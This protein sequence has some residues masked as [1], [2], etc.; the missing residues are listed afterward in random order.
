QASDGNLYGTTLRGGQFG[1]GT[2]YGLKPSGVGYTVLHSF[3]GVIAGVPPDGATPY[4]RLFEF[5]PGVLAGT[6]VAGGDPNLGTVYTIAFGGAPYAIIHT[7]VGGGDGANPTAELILHTDQSTGLTLMYGTT[8]NGGSA[9]LGTVYHLDGGGGNYCIAYDFLGGP[10]DGANPWGAVL[11]GST[12]FLYG[13]TRNGGAYG[14]GTIYSLLPVGA[15][16]YSEA[17]MYSFA[18]GF[19]PVPDGAN[20]YAAVIQSFLDGNLYGT[21]YDDGSSFLGTIYQ[22]SP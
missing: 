1:K 9:G 3:A 20:P 7:F 16:P 18:G 13:T 14:L 15:C 17:V 4:A 2:V 22:Q 5:T 21:C 19:G 11:S 10:N 12:G 8:Y 6:T